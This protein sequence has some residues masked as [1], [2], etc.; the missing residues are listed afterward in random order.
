MFSPI[1][2]WTSIWRMLASVCHL[3]AAVVQAVE[4]QACRH[5]TC[6]SHPAVLTSRAS[7]RVQ[8]TGEHAGCAFGVLFVA[9]NLSAILVSKSTL[10]PVTFDAD[11]VLQSTGDL[12][13]MG[14]RANALLIRM[15]FASYFFITSNVGAGDQ[16]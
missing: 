5:D 6:A 15:D 8:G 7:H 12:S 1:Q 10:A 16:A 4:V 9:A 3:S 2:E 14:P 11:V 13:F